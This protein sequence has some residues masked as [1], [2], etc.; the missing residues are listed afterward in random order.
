MKETMTMGEAL[1]EVYP[2]MTQEEIERAGK[3]FVMIYQCATLQ[4]NF[5]NELKD[6]YE[7]HN[8]FK[9]TIKHH[10]NQI[11]RL[12]RESVDFAV[13]QKLTD[14]EVESLVEDYDELERIIREFA[15]L[16]MIEE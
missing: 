7:K 12:V 10:Y 13:S 16:P 2:K 6:L 3:L 15:G 5:N 14:K 9:M 11:Q 4:M 1:K 8:K